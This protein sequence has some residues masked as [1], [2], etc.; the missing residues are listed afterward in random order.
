MALKLN[1]SIVLIGVLLFLARTEIVPTERKFHSSD[2]GEVWDENIDEDLKELPNL[3]DSGERMKMA[4]AFRTGPTKCNWKRKC[5]K[6]AC[7]WQ[8]ICT[9]A[10]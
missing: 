7:W 4:D 3:K 9:S 2:K 5:Y 8:R 10:G 6:N 1:Y